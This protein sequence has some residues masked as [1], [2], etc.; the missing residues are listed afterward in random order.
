[1]PLDATV[2]GAGANTYV[3]LAEFKAYLAT[4]LHVPDAVTVADD[5]QLEMALEQAGILFDIGFTWNG[6]PSVT[7]QAMAWPR[8]GLNDRN[9]QPIVNMAVIPTNIKIAHMEMA[10]AL[11]AGDRLAD[12]EALR[13][14]LSKLK[15][16]S[17]ELG[18]REAV[19]EV[20]AFWA[21][22][23]PDS[24]RAYLV[25]SWYVWEEPFVNPIL[26]L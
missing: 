16:G 7:T 3:L 4:R 9:G 22:H 18:F 5:A 2:A 24:V 1:M 13:Q 20:S 6:A 11:I 23:I 10:I 12:N 14:G 26:A 25:P 8:T 19:A 15:V 17:I 21:A